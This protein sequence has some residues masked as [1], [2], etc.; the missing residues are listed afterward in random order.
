ML[1][2]YR[3]QQEERKGLGPGPTL[4]RSCARAGIK[5][6]MQQESAQQAK[7]L[8][9]VTCGTSEEGHLGEAHLICPALKHAPNKHP[10]HATMPPHVRS[11]AQICCH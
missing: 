9:V 6:T 2:W 8:F 11:L 7:Q 1:D 3:Q 4:A 10:F 5:F